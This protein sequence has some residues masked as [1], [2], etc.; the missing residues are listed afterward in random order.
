[1]VAKY[2]FRSNKN[3]E[4]TQQNK[5]YITRKMVIENIKT[6]KIVWEVIFVK[7]H[8]QKKLKIR[9]HVHVTKM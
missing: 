8:A 6:F 3:N 5:Q 7:L 1:M 4:G 9:E 2:S